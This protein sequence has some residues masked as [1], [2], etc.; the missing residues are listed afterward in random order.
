MI[1]VEPK[2]L[3][4]KQVG[5]YLLGGI[6][7]RPIAFV[8]T[9]SADGINNLAPYSFF[10][11]FGQ[12][13]PVVAFSPSRRVR[14]NTVKDTYTNLIDNGEC[15]IHAVTYS[16]VDQMNLASCEFSSD[17]DE[18]SISGFTPIDSDLV[19]PKRVKESPFHMECKL[20][21]M[22]EL[23]GLAG[24]GNLAICEVVKFHISK[25]LID[26][27]GFIDP[28]MIDHV[29]RN[30][31]AWYTRSF[32]ESVFEVPKPG[33]IKGIGFENIPNFIKK[34]HIYSANNLGRF[35]LVNTV[36]DNKEV[37]KFINEFERMESTEETLFRFMQQNDYESML[38]V[39]LYFADKEHPKSKTYLEYTAKC[40]IENDARE[41]AWKVAIFSGT[42]E[43]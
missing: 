11:A 8:S 31:K 1:S 36:P 33:S 30:G 6:A 37:T 7:P 16:M 10:N 39:A 21:Q 38:K 35:G 17:V 43:L 27:D 25:E 5:K 24:S 4:I 29:G 42:I 32:G 13:P 28:Q 15:V 12:N 20:I 22:V 3:T 41:F 9:I 14:D 18:Y 2:N 34:S 23:G 26:E 40:A 19:T